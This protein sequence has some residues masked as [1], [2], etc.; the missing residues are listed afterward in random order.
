ML[1]VIIVGN[2]GQDSQILN[3]LLNNNDL[4]ILNLNKN[5]I[6]NKSSLLM[7]YKNLNFRTLSFIVKEY[8]VQKV[9]FTASKTLVK[10]ERSN[11]QIY[12]HQNE[13]DEIENLL[14]LCLMSCNEAGC[15]V[16]FIYFS[17]GLRFG[18]L[19]GE[20]D[21]QY[22]TLTQEYYGKH[23]LYCEK[24]IVESCDVFKKIKPFII[25]FFNHTSN[26]AKKNLFLNKIANSIINNDKNWLIQ[27]LLKSS[28]KIEFID[29]GCA[30]QYM[31]LLIELVNSRKNGNYIFATGVTVSTHYFLEIALELL[32]EKII[33]STVSISKPPF[34]IN[35]SKL[36]EALGGNKIDF[37]TKKNLLLKLIESKI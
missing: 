31:S 14:K 37:V 30:E 12:F 5:G 10:S 2:Q 16:D 35:N 4:R 13:F 8:N 26:Y 20:V 29:I 23:K 32:G 11:E 6:F 9:F 15:S 22:P 25:Y 21:E 34:T 18:Q 17:S 27:E 1:S 19:H 28:R 33:D 36:I 24:M 3:N 7:A